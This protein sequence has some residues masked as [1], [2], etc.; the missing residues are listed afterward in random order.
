M[1]RHRMHF[2]PKSQ[3]AF[4]EL[5]RLG[6]DFNKLAADK[7][8]AHATFWMPVAGETEIVAEWDYSDYST[9]EREWSFNMEPDVMALAGKIWAIDYVRPPYTELLSTAGLSFG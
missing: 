6:E 8:R 5:L 9:F 2:S 4:M 7:G 1:Y 3:E